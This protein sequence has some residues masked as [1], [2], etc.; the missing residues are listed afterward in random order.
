MFDYSLVMSL[1]GSRVTDDIFKKFS[2]KIKIIS[3]NIELKEGF[4]NSIFTKR[5]SLISNSFN[6]YYLAH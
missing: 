1:I 2:F 4:N 3:N 6:N 5:S